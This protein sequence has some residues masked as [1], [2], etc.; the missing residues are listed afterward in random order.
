MLHGT[1]II[2]TSFA[3]LGLLFAIAYFADQRADAGRP[4]INNA[5]VYSLSLAGY[6]TAGTF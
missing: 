3:Y 5:Y 2:F 6:S 4:V 1:F